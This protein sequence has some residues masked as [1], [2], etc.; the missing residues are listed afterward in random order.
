MQKMK[1]LRSDFNK[2]IRDPFFKPWIKG[3]IE[4]RAFLT[5]LQDIGINETIF[6][7]T[8]CSEKDDSMDIGVDGDQFIRVRK[9]VE[10]GGLELLEI[11][12]NLVEFLV[13]Q[14]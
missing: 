10:V 3:P 8:D 7:W 12:A 4:L 9:L 13:A 2:T 14:R 5:K 11:S 6:S 1:S